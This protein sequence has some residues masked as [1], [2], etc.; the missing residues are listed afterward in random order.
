MEKRRFIGLVLLTAVVLGIGFIFFTEPLTKDKIDIK[1]WKFDDNR[2]EIIVRNQENDIEPEIMAPIINYFDMSFSA[3][4]ELESADI[5]SLFNDPTSDNARINQNALDYLIDLR[6]SQTNDLHIGNYACGLSFLDINPENESVELTVI[7][8]HTVNFAFISDVDSISSGIKHTF[9]LKKDTE[10]YGIVEHHKEEDSFLMLEESHEEKGYSQEVE[11]FVLNGALSAVTQLAVEKQAFNNKETNPI[12]GVA[13]HPYDSDAAVAYA[14]T[15]VDPVLVIRNDNDF[16]NYDSYGG[17]CNNYTS[18]CLYA[19][20]IPM[21]YSGLM[22]TQWKWYGDEVNGYEV[23]EG[24]SPAWT[25]VNE[26]Y[27]YACENTDYGLAAVVDDNVYSGGPGDVL[28]YGNNGD[29]RHSVIIAEVI[30][31]EY[32]NVLDYLIY[33]N[34]TDRINYPA[35]AYGYSQ[36]RLIKIVGW[37]Q[38]QE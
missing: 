3:L 20:G 19:G 4:A 32:E 25:G 2:R 22:G 31:D 9:L 6:L 14:R 16:I 5:A 8:D 35:S 15:W 17:N 10:G 13:Q 11:D 21:D 24:R 37:S 12:K 23:P 27:A 30:K 38:A 34:T 18:Q 36:Q 1:G 29:W 26:F 28:Q 7:E 33:S